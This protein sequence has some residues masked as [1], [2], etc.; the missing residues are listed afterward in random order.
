MG[1]LLV[2]GE[3]GVRIDREA[4]LDLIDSQIRLDD[5]TGCFHKGRIAEMAF[6]PDYRAAFAHYQKAAKKGLAVEALKAASMSMTGK[7]VKSGPPKGPGDAELV[8]G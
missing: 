4:G 1:Y 6:L 3:N 2:A 7:G 8:R 5:W